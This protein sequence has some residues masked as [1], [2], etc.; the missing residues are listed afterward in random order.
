[1]NNSFKIG[2][3]AGLVAGFVSAIYTIFIHVPLVYELGAQHWFLPPPPETPF[4]KIAINEI[5]NGL[6]WGAIVGLIYA[7]V[8]RVIPGKGVSKGLV[9]G[10]FYY[11]ITNVYWV[12]YFLIYWYPPTMISNLIRLPMWI[13][14]GIVLGSL[15]EFLRGK[16]YVKKEPKVVQYSMM[17]GFQPG[18]IAG[19]V[20]A[21]S[22]FFT[23]LFIELTA[24][25]VIEPVHLMEI[26]LDLSFILSQLG[27]QTMWHMW[28]GIFLAL[29]FPKVYNL[30]PGKG[31]TK[32]LVY[33]LVANYL[34]IEVRS[35][36]EAI[37]Y[38]LFGIVV[39][40]L[41]VGPIYATIYGLILGYLY[42]PK[43]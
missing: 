8:Y 35:V 29:I 38:G 40:F 20:S 28:W 25:G 4:M 34:L 31:I 43:K 13:I 41:I 15:N 26:E 36:T 17:S 19:F 9:Y 5:I 10:L 27:S 23:V 24:I 1:M 39:S 16:Y 21:V 32:G 30:V 42:K 18:V 11:L 22:T 37:G 33:G 3:V 12:T 7:W 2:I 14:F 6:I